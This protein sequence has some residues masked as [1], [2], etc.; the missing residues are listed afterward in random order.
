MMHV[1]IPR[2]KVLIPVRDIRLEQ[3][4]K[5]LK[6][7]GPAL[8]ALGMIAVAFSI[9]AIV[10]H[11]TPNVTGALKSFTKIPLYGVRLLLI[12][13]VVMGTLGG[14]AT[15]AYL[16]WS[17]DAKRRKEQAEKEVKL[18]DAHVETLKADMHAARTKLEQQAL[19]LENDKKRAE[20]FDSL[21]LHYGSYRAFLAKRKER[22]YQEACA[23]YTCTYVQLER[24]F[25][26]LE[27]RV[28]YLKKGASE[29]ELETYGKLSEV[30]QKLMSEETFKEFQ[31]LVQSKIDQLPEHIEKV[32]EESLG[33]QDAFVNAFKKR[34]L[35]LKKAKNALEAKAWVPGQQPQEL[36]QRISGT[37]GQV[38]FRDPYSWVWTSM[39]DQYEN[40]LREESES[41]SPRRVTQVLLPME[42]K[43]KMNLIRMT[44]LLSEV[45]F[46]T[47]TEEA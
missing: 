6:V 5:P 26:A 9:V 18:L 33:K 46:L 10:A 1:V 23:H 16:C 4:P 7:I 15:G 13:G 47:K 20:L 21:P 25:A 31:D 45:E 22:A 41:P 17:Y 35:D 14:F 8:L 32:R 40:A 19:E 30:D 39:A 29:E 2:S 24:T 37:L 28:A 3:N 42:E 34:L 36:L 11:R 27:G 44:T 38:E 43:L 12:G